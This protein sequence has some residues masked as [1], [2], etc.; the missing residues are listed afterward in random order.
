M[1]NSVRNKPYPILCF[2]IG[3][4]DAID[5][6]RY[7]SEVRACC[8]SAFCV[9]YKFDI[10]APVDSYVDGEVERALAVYRVVGAG[11]D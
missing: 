7:W 6:I 5:H 9:L 2:S 10:G 11:V 3:V 8:E 1:H 4:V